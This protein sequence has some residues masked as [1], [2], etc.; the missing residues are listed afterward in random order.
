MHLPS[1]RRAVVRCLPVAAATCCVALAGPV[2]AMAGTRVNDDAYNRSFTYAVPSTSR[3]VRV[4]LSGIFKYAAHREP[5]A[6][7]SKAFWLTRIRLQNP[8]ITA[9]TF[10]YDP[11]SHAC[12]GN[13]VATRTVT[14]RSRAGPATP[15]AS[16]RTS[17]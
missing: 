9:T 5:I 14:G 2:P 12:T 3:C 16:A 13:P 8:A 6:T 17:A 4:D 7:G 11:V 10:T 15:A 1:G